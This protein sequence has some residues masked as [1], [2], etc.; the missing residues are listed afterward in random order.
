MIAAIL[1]G[2]E[3]RRIPR[4]KGLL[5]VEGKTIIERSLDVMNRIFGK[6][7]CPVGRVVINT[8]SPELYFRFGVPLVGD[9]RSERGPMTGIYSVLTATGEDSVFVVACDMPFLSEGLIRR[10]VDVS[11]TIKTAD[12][13]VPVFRGK[14]EPL[15]G[16]YAKSACAV[17][18]ALLAQGKKGL[19][20]MLRELKVASIS[21]EEVRRID[22]AGRSFVNINTLD[23]YEKIGGAP[24]L[25]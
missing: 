25:V 11:A 19:Q 5:R 7:A 3:N 6:P 18:E 22:P 23:E 20:E 14:V 13:V 9:I 12:A 2:G 16:I 1:A 10:L 15:F 4:L 21:E 24:C 8:N 17:M